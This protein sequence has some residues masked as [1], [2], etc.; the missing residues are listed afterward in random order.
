MQACLDAGPSSG[1]R[2]FTT[3]LS[4][5]QETVWNHLQQH[6]FVHKKPRQE[7]QELNEA[8]FNRRV[9]VCH[10]QLQNPLND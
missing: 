2:E 7:W 9:E 8:Q 1:S 4:F 3:E 5:D 10:Q 6:N